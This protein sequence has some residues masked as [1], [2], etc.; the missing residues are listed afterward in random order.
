[1]VCAI[2]SKGVVGWTLYETG[3]MT[4]DRMSDFINKFIK[5]KYKN[6]LIIMDNGGA[7]KK[8]CIKETIK[9]TNNS[10]LYSVPYRPKT[11]AIE[12]WFSQFKHYFKHDETGISFSN[13][14][15]SVRKAIRKI[16]SKS[17]LNYMEYAY[18]NKDI[19]TFIKNPSTRHKTLKNYKL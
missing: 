17:Y 16:S 1:M 19:R 2:N 13:L 14:K 7:H 12:S 6:N 11:N 18:T 15:K 4:G 10:L 9:E 8:E 3:G 5:N